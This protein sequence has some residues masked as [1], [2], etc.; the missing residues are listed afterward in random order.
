M[1]HFT[2]VKRDDPRPGPRVDDAEQAF[3]ALCRVWESYHPLRFI[4][5]ILGRDLRTRLG[6]SSSRLADALHAPDNA[7]LFYETYANPGAADHDMAYMLTAEGYAAGRR[8]GYIAANS[9]DSASFFNRFKA[10]HHD[11][12]EAMGQVD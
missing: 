10:E 9:N 6:W 8:K 5:P 2:A 3:H 7:R 4:N 11:L 12:L 1:A